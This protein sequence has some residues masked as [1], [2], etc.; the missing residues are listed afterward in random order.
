MPQNVNDLFLT[1]KLG[2]FQRFF[3]QQKIDSNLRKNQDFYEFKINN[4]FLARTVADIIEKEAEGILPNW[5]ALKSELYQS[6]AIERKL[7]NHPLSTD[8]CFSPKLVSYLVVRRNKT[9]LEFFEKYHLVFIP[10]FDKYIV[11]LY[12]KNPKNN[13]VE[14]F[15]IGTADG[16]LEPKNAAKE[17]IGTFNKNIFSS[18]KI[19][20]KVM[21]LQSGIMDYEEISECLF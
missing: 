2:L 12:S 18:W 16:Y 4:L 9:K 13:L 14:Y 21:L 5:L 11:T 3:L 10:G 17:I 15:A 1:E 7:S 6:S 20:R 19:K 8:F